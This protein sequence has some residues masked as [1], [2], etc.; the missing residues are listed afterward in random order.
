MHLGSLV[1]FLDR[2]IRSIQNLPFDS[3]FITPGII[4]II[5]L[6]IMLMPFIC[7][8]L[9]VTYYVFVKEKENRQIKNK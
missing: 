4:T 2:I 7:I 8:F 1:E 9:C 6:I 3:T 5:I